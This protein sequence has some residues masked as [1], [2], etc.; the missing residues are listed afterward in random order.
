MNSPINKNRVILHVDMDA[1]FA[2]I[3]Q[4]DHP[5]YRDKPVIVGADPQG[6]KGRGVVSTCSY[7]AR[8]FGVHSAMPVSRA[9]KL[10]P[11]GIY[12][13]PNGKLYSQVSDEIFEIFY[14]FSDAVEPLSIDEAFIDVT[15]SVKLFGEGPE[16]ARKLKD[17]IYQKERISINYKGAG[18][19]STI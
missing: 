5:E 11:H 2:A 1:F 6:G 10:C 7:E 17:R 15:G 19:E 3:E 9:Y 12:V 4:R 8:K 13:W 16:I 18:C 14:E